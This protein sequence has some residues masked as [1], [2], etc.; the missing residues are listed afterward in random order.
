MLKALRVVQWKSYADAT[1]FF[2]PITVLIGANASGK[3]NFLD[4]LRCLQRLASGMDPTVA[5]GGGEFVPPLRGGLLWSSLRGQGE[6][7]LETQVQ[8]D[9]QVEL[10][11]RIALSVTPTMARIAAENLTLRRQLP[12]KR[13]KPSVMEQT[14]FNAEV[15]GE[16]RLNVLVE[17]ERRPL[18]AQRQQSVAV[19][20]SRQALPETL[21]QPIHQLLNTL[22]QFFALEPHA[23][24]MRS[25]SPLGERLAAD[26]H[27]LAG[28]IAGMPKDAQAALTQQLTEFLQLLPGQPIRRVYAEVVGRLASDAMLYCEEVWPD[29]TVTTVDARAMSDGTLRFLAMLTALLTRPAGSLLALEEADTGLH[30]ARLSLLLQAIDQLGAQ[31]GLDV[32]LTTHNPGLLDALG[33]DM[34]PFIVVAHRPRG[35]GATQLT[36]L[37]EVSRL[38]SLLEEV[39]IGQ[40]V[41][42]GA[43]EAA[44]QETDPPVRLE[45]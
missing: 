33:A 42:A 28:F 39:P 18:I 2:D 1:L 14:L 27:N 15:I 13:G 7:L 16:H 17:R 32:L 35:G 11:H 37:D 12:A 44:L 24:A 6:I 38:H 31:R 22:T 5:L 36:V 19:Q 23:A 29:D 34:S 4:A 41:G 26:G 40:L 25:F 3:S 45:K 9:D 20:L 10:R 30:P 21:L 8:Q 43:V